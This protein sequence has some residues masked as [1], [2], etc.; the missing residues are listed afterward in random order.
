MLDKYVLHW[1][2]GTTKRIRPFGCCH[3]M[4]KYQLIEGGE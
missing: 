3:F 2:I 4:D 1:E